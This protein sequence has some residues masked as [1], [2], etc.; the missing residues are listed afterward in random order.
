M[1]GRRIFG[2]I[3]PERGLCQRLLSGERTACGCPFHGW[4]MRDRF[5][6][7]PNILCIL[8]S[9]LDAFFLSLAGL[10]H[11]QIWGLR[12]WCVLRGER[13]EFI[14]FCDFACVHGCIFD[15]RGNIW[16]TFSSASVQNRSREGGLFFQKVPKI[17]NSGQ[18]SAWP[19]RHHKL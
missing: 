9:T 16:R 7:G 6:I 12:H 8:G 15:G 13:N 10:V 19:N 1:C 11:L 2:E 5:S 17:W 3:L 4:I 14:T 18:S